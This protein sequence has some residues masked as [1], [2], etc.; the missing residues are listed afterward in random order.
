L[1]NPLTYTWTLTGGSPASSTTQNPTVCYSVPGTYTINL[2]VSNTYGTNSMSMNIVVAPAS[3][4]TSQSFA[5]CPGEIVSVGTSIYSIPGTYINTLLSSSGCDSI[6]TTTI[7]S[8]QP[9]TFSQNISICPGESFTVGNNVYATSGIF[10]DVLSNAVGCDST[11]ITT[12]SLNA[13]STFTQSINIC[14]G[15]SVSV[16]DSVYDEAGTYTNVLVASNGCD[17]SIITILT[18]E[19]CSSIIETSLGVILIYPNPTNNILTIDVEDRLIG[20]TYWIYDQTGRLMVQGKLA[21][22]SETIAVGFLSSG[23]YS[24]VI[25]DGFQQSFKVSKE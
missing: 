17:S 15:E 2:L 23:I 9:S 5:L 14:E 20:S 19:D 24:F 11:I 10:T 1:N 13:N 3:A 25:G 4:A 6:V 7:T 22:N 18:V 12:I 21:A 16:A 8:I